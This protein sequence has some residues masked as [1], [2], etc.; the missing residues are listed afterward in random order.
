MAIGL[1]LATLVGASLGVLGAGGS[2]VT[3]P[4]L[5]Y[6]VGL[7][8]QHA[9]ATSLLVVGLVATAGM[10][11]H[12]P[13]IR[14]RAGLLFGAAGALGIAPGVWLSHHV[15]STLLLGGFGALLL[16]AA[17]PLLRT[18][19]VAERAHDAHPL[20]ALAGGAAVGFATGFFGV[21]G[22]FLIVPA[23][24]TLVGL[25]LRGAAATSLLVIAMNCAAGLAG[26]GSTGAVEWRLGLAFGGV[27]LLAALVA[28]PLARGL[29]AARLRHAFAAMLIVLG[30]GMVL[31]SAVRPWS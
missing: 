19:P 23:L 21:G 17:A 7:D 10:A 26:H 18:T 8:V 30:A 2:I 24:M 12:W 9:A 27:A 28:T 22:G 6:V 25:D 31:Q 29:P 4:L 15:P 1:L 3:V 14:L 5:V 16:L 13:A 11:M 20:A